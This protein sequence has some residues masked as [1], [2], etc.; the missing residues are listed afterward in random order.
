MHATITFTDISQPGLDLLTLLTASS[1]PGYTVVQSK[2]VQQPSLNTQGRVS[3]LSIQAS[4]RNAGSQYVYRGGPDMGN[5]GTSQGK[6]LA[7]G[8]IDVMQG[9]TD[10]VHLSQ[11]YLRASQNALIAN[12]EW[13]YA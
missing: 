7:A 8:V 4:P 6:E 13:F 9:T 1:T 12:V 11:V 10:E 3:Y 2:G 5:A